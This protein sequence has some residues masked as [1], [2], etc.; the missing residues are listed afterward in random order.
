M[1]NMVKKRVGKEQ[2]DDTDKSFD[3]TRPLSGPLGQKMT[4]ETE[5]TIRIKVLMIPDLSLVL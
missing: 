3:D 2:R 4:E 1:R 5:E